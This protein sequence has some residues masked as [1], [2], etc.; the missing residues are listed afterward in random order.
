MTLR[1][2]RGTVPGAPPSPYTRPQ[3]WPKIL[4][5]NRT[6]YQTRKHVCAKARL[7]NPDLTFE[8]N[9]EFFPERFWKFSQ[10]WIPKP[11][12]WYP[13]LRFGSQHRIPKHLFFLIFWVSTADFGFSAG[14][15]KVSD[16]FLRCVSRKSGSQH[17]LREKPY[18]HTTFCFSALFWSF[19]PKTPPHLGIENSHKRMPWQQ[20]HSQ[21]EKEQAHHNPQESFKAKNSL[22]MLFLLSAVKV[23]FVRLFNLKK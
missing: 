6:W 18:R 2:C 15:W 5:K 1:L 8:K 12:F 7:R 17:Q 20:A 23:I 16:I 4:L 3:E 22:E 19:P 13:P 9:S 11:Q 21:P 14:R 10:G